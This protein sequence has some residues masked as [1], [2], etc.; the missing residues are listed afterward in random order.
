ME[1]EI[2]RTMAASQDQHWWFVGRRRILHALVERIAGGRRLDILEIGCGTGGNLAMLGGFGSVC[3][4]EIDE[5]ALAHARA[6]STADVRR[7]WLPDHLPLK[8]RERF[9]LVCMF[10]VLEHVAQDGEALRRVR[11]L[12]NE[13]GQVLV[14][15]PAYQWLFGHHDRM[16]H[17]HRRYSASQL[18]RT[19]RAEGFRVVRTGYFNT[20]LFPVALA[21]RGLARLLGRPMVDETSA[22]KPWLNRLLTA[23]FGAER[24]LVPRHFF[25]F[26][27]SAIALLELP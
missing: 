9:D 21:L 18:A 12:L 5:E 25:P 3:G 17:H 26:G 15:V 16:H 20:L 2:Y 19:A 22:P 23:V 27:T 1:R 7:G 11:G 6:T 8:E 4:I 24:L 10:D 13:G 14:T